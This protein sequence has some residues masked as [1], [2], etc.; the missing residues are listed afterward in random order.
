[1]FHVNEIIFA[2]FL[3]RRQIDAI[4][5]LTRED[6]KALANPYL[7]KLFDREHSKSKFAVLAHNGEKTAKEIAGILK[8]K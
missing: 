5:A 8:E 6:I 1:M 3:C 4:W 7:Q 2:T